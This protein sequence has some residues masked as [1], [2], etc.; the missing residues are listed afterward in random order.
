MQGISDDILIRASEGDM[1]AFEEIYRATSGCVYNA[2]FRIVNNREDAEEITQE[3]FLTIYQ[4]LKGF[5]FQS[6]F[7]TWVYRITVNSAINYSKKR[8]R[9]KAKAAEYDNGPWPGSASDEMERKI[10]AEHREKTIASMLDVLNPDQ[11]ACIVLRN[12]EGLSYR[13]IAESLRI[14]IN[15]VRSRLKRARETLLAHSKER[16]IG[17]EV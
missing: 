12:I 14:N 8:A 11:R 4:K 1:D 13:E 2:A 3:V 7:K 17:N 15:T 6:S 9:E 16:H 5:R 10:D